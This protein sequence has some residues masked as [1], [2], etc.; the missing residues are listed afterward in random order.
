MPHHKSI[1]AD[2]HDSNRADRKDESALL[3]RRAAA[4]ALDIGDRSAWYGY[5]IWAVHTTAQT[6]N[7]PAAF[8]LLLSARESEPEDRNQYEACIAR[9]LLLSMTQAIR[10]EIGR[11]AREPA[12]GAARLCC[13]PPCSIWRYSR[14]GG[15]PPSSPRRLVRS[16]CGA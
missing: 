2:A 4:A 13:H 14:E 10:P 3:F 6:G 15:F 7:Y 12:R 1:A 5:M 9:L 11:L 16:A 8:A